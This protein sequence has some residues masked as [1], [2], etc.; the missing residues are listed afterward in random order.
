MGISTFSIIIPLYNKER[1]I[2][3]TLDSVLAQ[4]VSDYEVIVVDDGS[5]DNGSE[6][7]KDYST[8]DSRV[9]YIYKENGGVSS[10]RN[11]GIKEAKG[12][13]I[14]FLDADDV[15]ES[16][17]LSVFVG[18]FQKYPSCRMFIGGVKTI[19]RGKEIGDI[20]Q[21]ASCHKTRFP[22]LMQWL[23]RFYPRPGATLVH[24]SLIREYGAFDE[25]MAFFEDYEFGWRMMQCDEVA[26]IAKPVVIYFQEDGGL[27]LSHH[28]PEKAMAWYIPTIQVNGIF[29][30]A[31]LYE[32]L[33][34]EINC[35]C[36]TPEMLTH[37]TKMKKT[38]FSMLY[39]ALHWLRQQ[40][41]RHHWI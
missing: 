27:S 23:N 41:V 22:Y 13:W 40:L 17:A 37:Y 32:I 4:T 25:R 9:R 34:F 15:L 16:D 28:Q 11:R 12:E 33:E 3:R 10:A 30:K 18:M 21:S 14:L 24:L 6:I 8:K 26:Y 38:N 35:W 1:Q 2:V 7:V 5:R 36:N 20:R 19:Q 31:L 39:V 29:S